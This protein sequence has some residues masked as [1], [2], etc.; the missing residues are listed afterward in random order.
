MAGLHLAKKLADHGTRP[1]PDHR[2]G[3]G[4]SPS[5]AKTG[6]LVFSSL[7]ENADIWSLPIDASR[8]QVKGPPE[9]LTRDLAADYLPSMS[10]DGKKL[11]FV[12]SRS[13][14]PDIWMKDLESGKEK[15]LTNLLRK[16]VSPRISPDGSLVSYTIR[17][18]R[19]G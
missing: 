13:G 16:R 6:R 7:V 2:I 17:T 15:P 12:S 8:G 3:T 9:Q 18:T 10:A 19:T 4:D 11:A 14:N 1:S 5:L